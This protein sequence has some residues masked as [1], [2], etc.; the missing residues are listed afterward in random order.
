MYNLSREFEGKYCLL[1]VERIES[2]KLSLIDEICYCSLKISRC[3]NCEKVTEV[4]HVRNYL[5]MMGFM[6]VYG[7]YFK[8]LA[9]VD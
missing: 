5:K 8:L 4:I 7:L 2:I 1:L 3:R 9:D 6:P